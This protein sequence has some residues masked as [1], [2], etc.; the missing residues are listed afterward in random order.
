MRSLGV[1]EC[2]QKEGQ[3]FRHCCDVREGLG[4]VHWA[5][6][7]EVTADLTVTGKQSRWLG[8]GRR[9]DTRKRAADAG[10]YF[11]TSGQRGALEGRMGCL[12]GYCSHFYRGESPM[13]WP[14][15]IR[16]CT[17]FSPYNAPQ[18]L[19]RHRI[20]EKPG[21]LLSDLFTRTLLGSNDSCWLLGTPCSLL[22]RVNHFQTAGGV[23][24]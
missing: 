9:W 14:V 20:T 13:W 22:H 16:H 17:A 19:G 2:L 5:G 1:K 21:L 6:D 7:A 10:L 11:K 18:S 8:L 23:L 3:L 24:A 4:E 12:Q 15:D